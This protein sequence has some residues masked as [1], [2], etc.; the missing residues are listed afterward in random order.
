MT[1]TLPAVTRE[2]VVE[3][4]ADRIVRLRAT[5]PGMVRVGLCGAQGS[6]KTTVAGA[7]VAALAAHDLKAVAFSIDDVYRTRAERLAL[8]AA[9]H[10]ICATRGPPGTH[11]IALAEATLDALGKPGRTALPAFDKATDDRAPPDGWPEVDGPL[12]A[13]ILE[14]WCV[15]A[16]P[17]PDAQLLAPINGLEVEDDEKAHWRRWANAA[18]A[19]D[20]QR[21]FGSLDTL[22]LLAAPGFEVVAEWRTQQER[23]LRART[24]AGMS[25]TEVARFVLFYER[26][27]RWILEEMPDRADWTIRLDAERRPIT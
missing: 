7:T 26:L 5:R 12:D 15:G 17:E 21:L 23:E 27:T 1:T 20:Y 11:D 24:G 25:D 19:G 9:V 2:K 10:P 8:A 22:V 18:L 6:G 13:V 3:P 4:L 14:G 16:R